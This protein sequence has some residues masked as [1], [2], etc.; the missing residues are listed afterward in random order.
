MSAGRPSTRECQVENA[1]P[2]S[3]AMI[4]RYAQGCRLGLMREDRS[5]MSACRT[6]LTNASPKR[7]KRLLSSVPTSTDNTSTSSRASSSV[8]GFA[9]SLAK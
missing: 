4:E 1:A 5:A 8:V 6:P 2:G 9:A 3:R 7:G